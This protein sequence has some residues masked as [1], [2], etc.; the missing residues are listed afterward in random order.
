MLHIEKS[1][2]IYEVNRTWYKQIQ[3]TIQDSATQYMRPSNSAEQ[4]LKSPHSIDQNVS[5][6]SFIF[7]FFLPSSL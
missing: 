5:S 3:I 2:D 1:K 4:K 6:A 7:F